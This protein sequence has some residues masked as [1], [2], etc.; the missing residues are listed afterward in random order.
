MK[1]E[2][3][4]SNLCRENLWSFALQPVISWKCASL[5]CRGRK[6]SS[7]LTASLSL[8]LRFPFFVTQWMHFCKWSRKFVVP[9]WKVSCLEHKLNFTFF[10]S[11]FFSKYSHT[12]D[13]TVALLEL[14]ITVLT[15][16]TWKCDTMSSGIVRMHIV[17][18]AWQ[19]KVR[20]RQSTFEVSNQ[21]MNL[22]SFEYSLQHEYM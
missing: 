18:K 15:I 16:N 2:I 14:A 13:T 20:R 5:H 8:L 11:V 10:A 17:W 9:S 4:S 22:R 3:W 1:V 7:E 21:R 6:N 12:S 19:A